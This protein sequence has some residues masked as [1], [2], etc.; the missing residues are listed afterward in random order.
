MKK[1]AMI[2]SI[3]EDGWKILEEEN[4]EVFEINDFS[5][6]NL[7]EQLS[8][9][10]GIALRTAKLDEEILRECPKLQIVARHGVGYDN[11][12]LNYLN[13]N[14]QALAIT[15]TANAVSV[16]EHV[17]TMFLC[18][19]K[20]IYKSDNFVRSGKFTKKNELPNFFELYKK[21]ILI[22]GFGR[23]GQALAITGTSNAVSVAEHVM[24]MFLC[25]VKQINKS[26]N[27][28]KSGKFTEKNE[29]PDFFE[30]YK[31][32]VLI[33]GFGRIGQSLAHRCLGFE[34]NI[35]IYDPFVDQ[36][37]IENKNCLKIGFDEGLSIADFISIHIPLN[38]DTN[39]LISKDQFLLMKKECIL[40]NTARGGIIDEEA[41]AWA[42]K[43]NKIY[44]AGLDV[45]ETEPP[46]TNNPLL[47]LDNVLLT[48]HNAALTLECRKRMAVETCQNILYYLND[49]A[50]LNKNN[51][52]NRKEL[53]L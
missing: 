13:Q 25:L 34:A 42:L 16:A 14:K 35:Y 46:S 12:D 45:F 31:K 37:A 36:Q 11:V 6:K 53:N 19:A 10:D 27:F 28:V 23:I 50:K 9:V 22:L 41:L 4:C 40:V 51:I 32:N 8:D 7:I 30:L 21:N 38:N 43:N 49:H 52:V 5:K 18:L 47:E 29:L 3:H 48:P 17:M 1:V 39:K 24:T 44:G 26:D 20:Q 15:G 2:G 33:M